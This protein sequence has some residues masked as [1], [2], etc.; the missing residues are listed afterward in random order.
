MGKQ[1]QLERLYRSLI[2]SPRA[3]LSGPSA[4]FAQARK[5]GLKEV[6]LDDCR[7]FLRSKPE[8]T[9]YRRARRNYPRNRIIANSCGEILQI[10]IMD[11]VREIQDNDG[12]RYALIAYDTYSKYLWTCPLRDRKPD[13]VLDGLRE[14]KD[15]L[16]FRIHNIYWDKVEPIFTLLLPNLNKT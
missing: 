12:I 9:H 7:R 2:R 16:P 11:M 1:V 8:Y 6:S 3:G 10:D 4:L 14:L 15:D 13:S 5:T